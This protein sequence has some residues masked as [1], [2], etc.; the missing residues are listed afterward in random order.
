MIKLCYENNSHDSYLGASIVMK[1]FTITKKVTLWV[2]L[3]STLSLTACITD[4]NH[5]VKHKGSNGNDGT[6]SGLFS[7][8]KLTKFDVQ[9]DKDDNNK[10]SAIIKTEETIRSGQAS[11]TDMPIFGKVNSDTQ[12][13]PKPTLYTLADFFDFTMT[14]KMKLSDLYV[15]KSNLSYYYDWHDQKN[16]TSIR[17]SFDYQGVDIAHISGVEQIATKG[18]NT[19]LNNLPKTKQHKFDFPNGAKCYTLNQSV[20]QPYFSFSSNDMTGYTNLMDWQLS[21]REDVH[22]QGFITAQVG[23]ANASSAVYYNLPFDSMTIKPTTSSGFVTS[24]SQPSIGNYQYPAAVQYHG[25]IYHATYTKAYDIRPNHDPDKDL[26]TCQ[27]YNK[28]AS[29]YISQQIGKYYQ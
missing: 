13:N 23:D 20:S 16:G 9:Y 2:A 15:P 25:K 8:I 7:S 29:D 18:I 22:Q 14:P 6:S 21:M 24:H 3:L 5:Q 19:I 27:A 10:V 17:H 28:V 26:V 11:Y 12:T 4:E 1:T